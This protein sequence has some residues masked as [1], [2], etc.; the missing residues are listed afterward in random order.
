MCRRP[1]ASLT[2]NKLLHKEMRM[3]FLINRRIEST[4]DN[5]SANTGR[6]SGPSGS[7]SDTGEEGFADK[8]KAKLHIGDK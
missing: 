3:S 7:S 8:T 5:T 2:V 1:E 6:A 4:R